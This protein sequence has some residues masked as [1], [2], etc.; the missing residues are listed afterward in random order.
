MEDDLPE[1]PKS[2][3]Y[4]SLSPLEHTEISDD[5]SGIGSP[6]WGWYVSTTPPEDYY[7]PAVCAGRC[8]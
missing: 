1:C 3:G 2:P 6:E 5:P 8:E 4:M 7:P